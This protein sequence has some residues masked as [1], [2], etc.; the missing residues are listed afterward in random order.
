[1]KLNFTR[2]VDIKRNFNRFDHLDSGDE[3]YDWIYVYS[4]KLNEKTIFKSK[5]PKECDDFE[6]QLK[7]ALNVKEEKQIIEIIGYDQ[8][9]K[10]IILGENWCDSRSHLTIQMYCIRIG[11]ETVFKTQYKQERD[12]LLKR[13][14]SAL[15]VKEETYDDFV[16]KAIQNFGVETSYDISEMECGE[17]DLEQIRLRSVQGRIL[18]NTLKRIKKL[19][20]LV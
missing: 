20:S 18:L 11:Y 17:G 10:H 8:S 1:M 16:N 3:Q 2:T 13:L 19:E 15:N 14:K 7:S 4:V 9:E 5:D 12:T 6:N